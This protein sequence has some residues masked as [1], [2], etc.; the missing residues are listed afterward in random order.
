MK[1]RYRQVLIGRKRSGYAAKSERRKDIMQET[2][3]RNEETGRE[4][5]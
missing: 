4:M 2:K 1:D 5:L 3:V